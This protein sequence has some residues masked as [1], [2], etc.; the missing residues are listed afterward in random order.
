MTNLSKTSPNAFNLARFVLKTIPQVHIPERSDGQITTHE[1]IL[2]LL[3]VWAS[4]QADQS[5]MSPAM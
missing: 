3:P 2:K 4:Y 1:A 5:F